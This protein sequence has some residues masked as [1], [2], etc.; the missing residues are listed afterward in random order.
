[1]GEEGAQVAPLFLWLVG[2]NRWRTYEPCLWR[3]SL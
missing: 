2:V 3:Q 1:M